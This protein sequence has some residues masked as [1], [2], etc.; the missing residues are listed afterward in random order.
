MLI[1]A[2]QSPRR[3]EILRNA[4]FDFVVRPANVDEEPLPRETPEDY[5]KRV[6]LDK[7]MAVEAG[8]GDIILGADTTVVIDGQMLGKPENAADAARM[9]RLLSGRRHE[10]M[11]GISLKRGGNVVVDWAVTAVCFTEMSD[12]EIVD[13]IKSG[14]PM[15][16]AGAYAIQGLAAKFIERIDGC[17]SNVVGLPVA[18]VYRHLGRHFATP[19]RGGP[20]TQA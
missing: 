7:A 15:D 18:L 8:A 20:E 6:A 17:Y 14:E 19:G 5:V 16:K 2:S 13:Y 1:L 10:V 3:A 4:G 12:A 9:L 11:T